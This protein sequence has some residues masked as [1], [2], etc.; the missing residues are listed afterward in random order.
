MPRRR[1]NS[2]KYRVVV[3]AP[4]REPG[5]AAPRELRIV[6]RTTGKASYSRDGKAIALELASRL[7]AAT[8]RELCLCLD[9]YLSMET[10][11][12]ITFAE[13]L[14]KRPASK[15]WDEIDDADQG[16]DVGTAKVEPTEQYTLSL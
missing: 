8:M 14:A 12:G 15:T 16:G 6:F 5:E 1:F 10:R 9:D 3:T 11:A 13:L 7:P 4:A 2:T